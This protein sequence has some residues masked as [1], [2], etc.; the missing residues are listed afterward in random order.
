M[1]PS[2]MPHRYVITAGPT[3]E[4]IDAVRFLSNPSS[5]KMGFAI[6]AAAARSGFEVVLVAGPCVLPTPKGVRRIDVVSALDMFSAVKRELRAGDT[7]VAVAAVA[8][9][10]PARKA[11][12]KLKKE[13][14][15][16]VLR[17]VRNPDI[18]KS[19]KAAVKVGFA[20]ETDDLLRNAA[21]KCRGKKLDMIVANDVSVK[22]AGFGSDTNKVVLVYADGRRKALPMATKRKIAVKIVEECESFRF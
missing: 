13:S 21:K 3:R 17:L 6:A 16:P 22:G 15:P 20:A 11:R 7:F 10:R 12:G 8:D 14:M 5:G 19:A 4:Y 2:K 18:L 1:K 9:W